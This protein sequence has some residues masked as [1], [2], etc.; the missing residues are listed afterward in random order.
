MSAYIGKELKSWQFHF[1][2]FERYIDVAKAEP[3]HLKNN[4]IKEYF[5]VLFKIANGQMSSCPGVKCF[6]EIPVD[7]TFIKFVD[8]VRKDI[9]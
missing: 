8:F 5:M 3:L 9:G 1:P 7:S 2:L 4:T 6:R